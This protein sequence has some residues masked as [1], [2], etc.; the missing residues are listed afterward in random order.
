MEW[1]VIT[2]IVIWAIAH[3]YMDMQIKKKVEM[4]EKEWE[5]TKST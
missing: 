4:M 1:V 2:I 3:S 5:A